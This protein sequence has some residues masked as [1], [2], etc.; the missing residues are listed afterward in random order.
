VRVAEAALLR[1]AGVRC[2]GDL[3]DG[4]LADA[5]RTAEASKC[6]AELWH[7]VLPVE[8]TLARGFPLTWPELALGAGE[9]FELLAA[10]SPQ[11][12]PALQAAWPAGTKLTV[13]GGLV[14]GSG[15]RLLD[16]EGGRE[17]ALPP[18]ASGHFTDPARSARD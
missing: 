17:L 1:D 5:R 13:V 3:S 8:T 10:V 15:L 7:D 16:N 11:T 2:A 6:G 18:V 4:L 9:D 14:E 12:L